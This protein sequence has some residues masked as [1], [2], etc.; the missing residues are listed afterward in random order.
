MQILKEYSKNQ[1]KGHCF[2]FLVLTTALVE[3][4]NFAK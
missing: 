3:V 1:L 2:L 4:N